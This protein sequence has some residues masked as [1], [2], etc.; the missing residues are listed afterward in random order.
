MTSEPGPRGTSRAPDTT[1]AADARG[2][3]PGQPKDVN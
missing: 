2:T 3:V 1:H